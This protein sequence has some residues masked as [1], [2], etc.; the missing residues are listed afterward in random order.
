MDLS[1]KTIGFAFTGSFCTFEKIKDALKLLL[2]ENVH[3]IPIFSFNAYS[4]DSRF[5]NAASFVTEIESITHSL[6]IH[7]IQDAEI[8]GPNK[9]LDLMIIAP[10]TGNTMAKLYNGITDTPVLMAAKAH[11]RNQAPLV[12][13]VST[14]DALSMNFKT[15]GNLMNIK[16]IYFVPF[17]E[18][19]PEKKPASMIAHTE[20]IIPTLKLALDGIQIQPV[21][22]SPF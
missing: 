13:S 7:T 17:G 3:I 5:G 2:Q 9:I 15:I 1:G 6:S 10:C 19:Q 14:N 11:L 18:D 8:F 21:L 16:N 20:L 4:I 12:L 22:Q